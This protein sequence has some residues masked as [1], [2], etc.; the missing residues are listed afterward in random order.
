M[1]WCE[2]QNEWPKMGALLQSYWPNLT[3]IDLQTVEGDRAKLALA[4]GLDTVC[5]P[6]KARTPSARLRRTF[7]CRAL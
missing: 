4:I 3:Q 2:I 1:N 5:R 7:A 6:S